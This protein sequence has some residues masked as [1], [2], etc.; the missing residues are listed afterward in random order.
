MLDIC[1][2]FLHLS[3]LGGDPFEDGSFLATLLNTLDATLRWFLENGAIVN[4]ASSVINKN[5]ASDI[6]GFSHQTQGSGRV[7]FAAVSCT[8]SFHAQRMQFGQNDFGHHVLEGLDI[9]KVDE[10]CL[11]G[12]WQTLI[13][14]YPVD[15]LFAEDA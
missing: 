14:V 4:V 10:I 1:E 3:F 13:M 12:F 11:V 9:Q 7:S 6:V 5:P 2:H 8:V 15:N